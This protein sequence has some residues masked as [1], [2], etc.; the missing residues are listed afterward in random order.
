MFDRI[1]EMRT[2]IITSPSFTGERVLG[3]ILFE[4]TMDR[5][6]EGRDTPEYLWDVKGVVPFLKVDQGLADEA[7]GAQV[8]KP[9]PGLDGCSSGRSRRVCSAPRCAR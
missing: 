3:A 9:M 5:E 4:Q 2:R 8:M 6:I 1:H 7:D